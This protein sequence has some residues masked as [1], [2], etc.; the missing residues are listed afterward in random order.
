MLLWLYFTLLNILLQRI[1]YYRW[2]R[3][4]ISRLLLCDS[5]HH[6]PLFC[7]LHSN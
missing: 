1:F 2:I 6:F 4:D 5:F 3:K 7:I